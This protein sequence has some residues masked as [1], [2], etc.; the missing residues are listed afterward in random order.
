MTSTVNMLLMLGNSTTF[1]K[2]N[3]AATDSPDEI[4]TE[5]S[6]QLVPAP[7]ESMVNILKACLVP[8]LNPEKKPL[9]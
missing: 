6:P 9:K 3:D 5:K 4:Y 2:T 8:D 7:S 1:V